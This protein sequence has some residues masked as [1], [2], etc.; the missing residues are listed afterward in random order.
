MQKAARLQKAKFLAQF[1]KTQK[2]SKFTEKEKPFFA[3]NKNVFTLSLMNM[4]TQTE[5]DLK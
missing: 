5:Y 4:L 3:K 2:R 1:F